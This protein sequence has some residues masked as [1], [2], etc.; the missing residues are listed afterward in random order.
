MNYK[1]WLDRAQNRLEDLYRQ[2]EELNKEIAAL[3]RAIEGCTPL[4]G[5]YPPWS[6]EMSVGITKAVTQVFKNSP[7]T[8]YGPTQ[9]RDMLVQKGV[10]LGQQNPLATIHQII[11]RLEERRI[12]TALNTDGRRTY[13]YQRPES[14]EKTE[15]TGAAADATTSTS[16]LAQDRPPSEAVTRGP[17]DRRSKKTTTGAS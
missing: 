13:Y 11:S 3:Q 15:R 1:A 2:R 12:I 9:I 10:R 17:R 4:V 14:T 16:R 7:G 8:C 6:R 5:R